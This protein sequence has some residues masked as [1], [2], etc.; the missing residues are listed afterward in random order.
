[1]TDEAS[2][3]SPVVLRNPTHRNL[4]SFS[5]TF[6]SPV[7]AQQYSSATFVSLRLHFHKEMLTEVKNVII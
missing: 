6:P 2:L 7:I 4:I 3:E 5:T 1:M